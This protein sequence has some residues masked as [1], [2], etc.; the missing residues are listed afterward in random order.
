MERFLTA[1]HSDNDLS[2][3]DNSEEETHAVLNALK[4]DSD[5]ESGSESGKVGRISSS[6]EES[7]DSEDSEIHRLSKGK[8]Q[9][10]WVELKVEF[11]KREAERRKQ[12]EAERVELKEE[13]EAALG[14]HDSDY[15]L[16]LEAMEEFEELE[17]EKH[18]KRKER[19][20]KRR[21]LR[22]GFVLPIVT[23]TRIPTERMWQ[24]WLKS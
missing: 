16:A 14:A 8:E 3:I 6:D 21:R 4:D 7:D 24:S 18:R 12:V 10:I 13:W 9:K 23:W 2:D 20:Q 11:G 17:K 15:C 19:A 1:S 5:D 22:I